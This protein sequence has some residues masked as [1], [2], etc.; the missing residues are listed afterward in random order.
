MVLGVKR[1]LR[2]TKAYSVNDHEDQKSSS[3]PTESSRDKQKLRAPQDTFD[4]RHTV[5]GALTTVQEEEDLEEKDIQSD[6]DWKKDVLIEFLKEKYQEY[7]SS[8]G[9]IKMDTSDNQNYTNGY[10][11]TD[12]DDTMSEIDTAATGGFKRGGRARASLPVVRHTPNKSKDK[13]LGLIYLQYMNET[14][15]ALM[16]NEI[17]G[18]DTVR[19]LFVRSFKSRLNME[20]MDVP[21]RKI[22]IRDPLTEIFYELEN[23]HE[24]KDRT[25]LRIY[26][27]GFQESATDGSILRSSTSTPVDMS[28]LSE[29]EVD[30]QVRQRRYHTMTMPVVNE[31]EA[32]VRVR[33]KSDGAS[34][35]KQGLP[36]QKQNNTPN[37]KQQQQQV[38]EKRQAPPPQYFQRGAPERAT[39]GGTAPQRPSQNQAPFQRG[40]PGRASATLPRGGETPRGGIVDRRVG[41]S[42]SKGHSGGHERRDK[43]LTAPAMNGRVN[44]PQGGRPIPSGSKTL[45]PGASLEMPGSSQSHSDS[46][47]A[48]VQ[49]GDHRGPQ[50]PVTRRGSDGENRPLQTSPGA[51]HHQSSRSY[52]TS[53]RKGPPQHN[54][55]NPTM[56]GHRSQPDLRAMPNSQSAIQ[57]V[58]QSEDD[59]TRRIASMEAQIANLA[60][61][62]RTAL[63]HGGSKSNGGSPVRTN[64]HMMNGTVQSKPL[65]DNAPGP[66]RQ[67]P[68]PSHPNGQVQGRQPLR[69]DRANGPTQGVG[70]PQAGINSILAG[71]GYNSAQNS[72]RQAHQQRNQALPQSSAHLEYDQKEVP[73]TLNLIPA[74]VEFIPPTGEPTTPNIG[75]IST[76]DDSQ[77]SK[78]ATLQRRQNGPESSRRSHLSK[79]IRQLRDEHRNVRKMHLHMVQQMNDSFRSTSYKI[80]QALDAKPGLH[81]HPIRGQRCQ[82]VQEVSKYKKKKDAIDNELKQLESRVEKLRI[83]TVN[84]RSQVDIR[85]V[86]N[87]AQLLGN[88]S[89]L[90]AEQKAIFP[91]L[92]D[93]LKAV[94]E[95]EMEIVVVEEKFL[96][97]EPGMLDDYFKRCKKLTGTLYTLKR[98]AEVQDLQGSKTDLSSELQIKSSNQ[99]LHHQAPTETQPS[100][101]QAHLTSTLSKRFAMPLFRKR[102]TQN[103]DQSKPNRWFSSP[104]QKSRFE[105]SL[106]D[107]KKNLRTTLY[108]QNASLRQKRHITS[109]FKQDHHDDM[110]PMV[111]PEKEARKQSIKRKG[112]PPPPPPRR[113]S[114]TVKVS[115][116]VPYGTSRSSEAVIGKKEVQI[117]DIT[118]T[119]GSGSVPDISSLNEDT[120]LMSGAHHNP[121]SSSSGNLLH[122]PRARSS[123]SPSHPPCTTPQ[124]VLSKSCDSS[125]HDVCEGTINVHASASPPDGRHHHVHAQNMRNI[126]LDQHGFRAIQNGVSEPDIISSSNQRGPPKPPRGNLMQERGQINT[127][128]NK[129]AFQ[130]VAPKP[131]SIAAHSGIRATFHSSSIPLPASK[132][133]TMHMHPRQTPLNNGPQK[134]APRTDATL[135]RIAPVVSVPQKQTANEQA[136]G[137]EIVQGTKMSGTDDCRGTTDQRDQKTKQL[138]EQYAKL[139][140][141]QRDRHK[142]DEDGR[143]ETGKSPENVPTGGDGQP[144]KHPTQETISQEVLIESK[145]SLQ[146]IEGSKLGDSIDRALDDLENFALIAGEFS[147]FGDA[148][149]PPTKDQPIL[150]ES[151]SP[152]HRNGPAHFSVET[153]TSHQSQQE[154]K[155]SPLLDGEIALKAALDSLIDNNNSGDVS[156]QK[157]LHAPE[158]EKKKSILK[159]SNFGGR[160]D[161]NERLRNIH[162]ASKSIILKSAS[163]NGNNNIQTF[164][165]EREP[166][167]ST[168]PLIVD[169]VQPKSEVMHI[170]S[171]QITIKSPR[172]EIEETFIF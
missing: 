37:G 151:C 12:L 60:G 64:P 147:S 67:Q 6:K 101:K 105:Q 68:R 99:V 21:A 143:R 65:Q 129:S 124:S 134:H 31:R 110:T 103:P 9:D 142:K 32:G 23:P 47:R 42:P 153:S 115:P 165:E 24:V 11:E 5:G 69:T 3:S 4:R 41:P 79:S 139:R 20:L 62:V 97:D 92:A 55:T 46:Q 168:K 131:R 130:V 113:S 39:V 53:P 136:P 1:G 14:K 30:Q 45:P 171:Q 163:S 155:T 108:A 38:P 57:H 161:V 140:A 128:D 17:T 164:P 70:R 33:T 133:A 95:G 51:R 73:K 135:G 78:R 83:E 59:T 25:V 74:Q 16:P 145:R 66:S 52:S 75:Y 100:S 149:T 150:L 81:D 13:P 156:S 89:K 91:L 40:T 141:L 111:T 35:G 26:E 7:S 148:T 58:Q 76:S 63:H 114:S 36:P 43:P 137:P 61:M 170:Y 116:V 107:G 119:P 34:S 120:L 162:T 50:G 28:Y 118:V 166:Q 19:A 82:V 122:P 169:E 125:L 109:L 48:V 90:I 172:G 93:K 94:M 8:T 112:P 132:K 18:M 104:A 102:K 71:R 72:P 2:V 15:R 86:D 88:N 49:R 121:L 106:R 54:G 167:S 157:S 154:V 98:L 85:S 159:K 22:Y 96:R 87:L 158:R 117:K 126:R 44:G 77:S 127:R 123:D 152:L 27:P 80:R 10:V 160:E 29:P 144:E 84:S 56:Q 138:K 146:T